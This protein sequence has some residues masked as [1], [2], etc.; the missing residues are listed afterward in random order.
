[1]EKVLS[2]WKTFREAK[3]LGVFDATGQYPIKL[4]PRTQMLD[5]A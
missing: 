2:E 1:M 5:Q 3:E 4:S